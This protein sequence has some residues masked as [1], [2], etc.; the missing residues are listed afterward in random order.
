[1]IV[2]P[3]SSKYTSFLTDESHVK[4]DCEEIIFPQTQDDILQCIKLALKDNK[5]ITL[6]G[7]RTGLNGA[8]VP[9]GH[10]VINLSKMNEIGEVEQCEDGAEIFVQCGAALGDISKLAQ[11]KGYIF[12]VNATEETASAGGMFST[13]AQGPNSLCYSSFSSYVKSVSF[14]FFSGESYEIN[15]GD[16]VIKDKKLT[17]PNGKVIDFSNLSENLPISFYKDNTDLIDFLAGKEGFFGI[18]DSFKLKLLKKPEDLWGIVLFFDCQ[19]KALDFSNLL[20]KYKNESARLTTAEYFNEETIELIKANLKNPL[21]SK[22]P[23]LPQTAKAAIYVELESESEDESEIALMDILDMFAQVGAN[24]DDTW[25]QNGENAVKCFRNMRHA[26]VSILNEDMNI[27]SKLTGERIETDI[28]ANP[29]KYEDY[30]E[31]YNEMLEK[32]SLKA[33]IYGCILNNH[34]HAAILADSEEKFKDAKLFESEICK[35]A[36]EDNA[37]IGAKYGIGKVKRDILI[38][39]LNE[40]D[41]TEIKRIRDIFDPNHLVNP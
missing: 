26:V 10:T 27:H 30:L 31:L 15:R 29:R 14:T 36:S 7:A 1:M 9:K 17:L 5:R 11:S 21:L 37:L 22:L 6:Q 38:N 19:D 16:Y 40:S 13:N 33:S 20:Y 8:C 18:A 4:G 25:A 34:L 3:I 39:L 35:K 41:K 24:E 12:P 28:K 23:E 32:Y 2:E